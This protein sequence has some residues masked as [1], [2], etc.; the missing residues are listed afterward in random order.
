MLL[1]NKRLLITGVF[2]QSSIA[3]GV[4]RLAQRQGAEVVL[5][6]FGRGLRL[7]GRVARRLPVAP[8]VLELDVTREE[9][10]AVV[11]QALRDRWGRVDGILH[12][13]AFAPEQAMG[14][15]FLTAGWED[16]A[17][18]VRVSAY[19]FVALGRGMR[20]LLA[21]AGGGAIV[22]LDFDAT[23]AWPA[24]DWMGVAKASLESC[25]RYLAYDLGPQGT[26]VNLVASGPL[27]TAAARGIPGA[28]AVSGPWH[29]RAPLGW[30][31]GD[32]E[33]VARVV[34]ALL[35]DWMPAVTGEIVHADGGHH[36]IGAVPPHIPDSSHAPSQG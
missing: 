8:E 23:Y 5:T 28:E 1:A 20:G 25:C 31:L 6:G 4:A 32:N 27:H 10:I 2:N 29:R 11:A 13:V 22:G 15:G 24:Y 30:D 12:A 16:V 9:H 17:T 7:T 36:A 19:S 34:C 18:A 14:G 26:R 3:F 35:S 33:P 21:D